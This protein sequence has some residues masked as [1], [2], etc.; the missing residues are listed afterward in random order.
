M[1]IALHAVAMHLL[2]KRLLR[3]SFRLVPRPSLENHAH[4]HEQSN[5]FT[6]TKMDWHP[7]FLMKVR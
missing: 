5:R 6:Y 7:P 4:R 3:Q 2:L 1:P